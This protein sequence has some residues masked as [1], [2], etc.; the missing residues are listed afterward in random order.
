MQKFSFIVHLF[1]FVGFMCFI[2]E[3]F[4]SEDEAHMLLGLSYENRKPL[5]GA[6]L[7]PMTDEGE[8][9]PSDSEEDTASSTHEGEQKES[10]DIPRPQVPTRGFSPEGFLEFLQG[11]EVYS[12]GKTVI[13]TPIEGEEGYSENAALALPIMEVSSDTLFLPASYPLW[14]TGK[15]SQKAMIWEQKA[16]GKKPVLLKVL[17]IE[18][19]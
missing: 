17:V 8:G 6:D 7:N 12:W 11:E 13:S 10:F 4:A 5:A 1:Q 3:G 9:L 16:P 2:H 19:E 14:E 18:A 15:R